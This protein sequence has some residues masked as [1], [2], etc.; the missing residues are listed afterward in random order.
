MSSVLGLD[1]RWEQL[2]SRKNLVRYGR[3]EV[4]ELLRLVVLNFLCQPQLS[5]HKK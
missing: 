1:Y 4:D 3:D 2:Y 5:K